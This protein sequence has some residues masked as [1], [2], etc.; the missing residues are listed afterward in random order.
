MTTVEPDGTIRTACS[1][2]H[3]Y[4]SPGDWFVGGEDEALESG[5]RIVAG[6]LMCPDCAEWWAD[7]EPGSSA[8][9]WGPNDNDNNDKK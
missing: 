3:A 8:T 9:E 7:D 1:S 5:W 6:T 2:C 4:D